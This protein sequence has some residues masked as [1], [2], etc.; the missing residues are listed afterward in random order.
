MSH[1]DPRLQGVEGAGDICLG[2][3]YGWDQKWKKVDSW[4]A[5]ALRKTL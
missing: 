3:G 1:Q 5:L 4:T 2:G